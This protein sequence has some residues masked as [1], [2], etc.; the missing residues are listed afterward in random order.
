MIAVA[1]HPS[2]QRPARRL[3][4]LIHVR[5]RP[6]VRLPLLAVSSRNPEHPCTVRPRAGHNPHADTNRAGPRRRAAAGTRVRRVVRRTIITAT[7]T[8]IVAATRR[9]AAAGGSKLATNIKRNR[10]IDHRHQRLHRRV[11]LLVQPRVRVVKHRPQRFL[12]V[13]RDVRQRHRRNVPGRRRVVVR[14]DRKHR[15]RLERLLER[16]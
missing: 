6:S 5:A 10:W 13:Y 11:G 12:V 4:H 2:N 1:R 9:P 3:A 15:D 16:V 7:V 8:T 14:P